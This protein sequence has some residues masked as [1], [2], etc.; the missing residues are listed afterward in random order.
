M[1]QYALAEIAVWYLI[2]IWHLYHWYLHEWLYHVIVLMMNHW[3]LVITS[4][5]Y[6]ILHWSYLCDTQNECLYYVWL[7]YWWNFE[8]CE[9][10]WSIFGLCLELTYLIFDGLHY[11]ILDYSNDAFVKVMPTWPHAGEA[12]HGSEKLWAFVWIIWHVWTW[13]S[14]IMLS[15]KAHSL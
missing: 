10:Q 4:V 6:L 14:K 7:F 1:I 15:I 8:L 3:T 12:I 5:Q 2:M 13:Q 11:S 9:C